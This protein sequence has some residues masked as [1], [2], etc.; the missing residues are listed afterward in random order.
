MRKSRN[1]WRNCLTL[2][3]TLMMMSQLCSVYAITLVDGVPS[4]VKNAEG[5]RQLAV[6]YNGQ[7]GENI[8]VE[9]KKER[10][11]GNPNEIF[12]ISGIAT[13]RIRAYA[14]KTGSEIKLGTYVECLGED[15][16]WFEMDWRDREDQVSIHSL[17][18]LPSITVTDIDFV[19]KDNETDNRLW[20]K[21]QASTG[22][23]FER[24]TAK[25][26]QFAQTQ[27]MTITRTVTEVE[28][29]KN[30]WDVE[31]KV[32]GKAKS[33]PIPTDVVLVLDRSGSMSKQAGDKTRAQLV[34]QASQDLAAEL[35]KAKNTRVAVV[36]FG[37]GKVGERGNKFEHYKRGTWTPF[38][39][40]FINSQWESQ[41]YSNYRVETDF[42]NNQGTLNNAIN[43]ALASPN[44]GTPIALGL[45][46]AGI[47]LKD[48]S[49][50]NKIVILLSDGDATYDRAGGGNGSDMS[51]WIKSDLVNAA[52]Q[53]KA[54]KT[55]IFTIAAG[56]GIS[57]EGK[58]VLQQCASQTNY[59]YEAQDTQ[60][61]LNEV[62][63]DVAS[64]IETT[65]STTKLIENINS[66]FN[67]VIP[68]GE[69]LAG[70]VKVED[71]TTFNSTDWSKVSA[72][73]TQ[74][75]IA[76]NALSKQGMQWEIGDVTSDKPAIIRYRVK[77][78]DGEL[79]KL[80][81]ISNN[82]RM[83]YTDEKGKNVEMAVPN[84]SLKA[85][86]AQVDV[87]AYLDGKEMSVPELTVWAKVP[88]D[89]TVGDLNLNGATKIDTAKQEMVAVGGQS[90]EEMLNNNV[91]GENLIVTGFVVDG[92]AYEPEELI[93]NG[94]DLRNVRSQVYQ[95][96]Q[97]PDIDQVVDSNVNFIQPEGITNV[98]AEVTFKE[99]KSTDIAYKLDITPLLNKELDGKKMMHFDLS[100][101][102][103]YVADV[104]S[105]TT[106]LTKDTN[107]SVS[108]DASHVTINFTDQM[109]ENQKLRIG[110]YIPTKMD[111]QID[112]K[113]YKNNYTVPKVEIAVPVVVAYKPIYTQVIGGMNREV[114]G[115]E[116]TETKSI[117]LAYWEMS[118]IS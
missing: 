40:Q 16:N 112:Y 102:S 6:T 76:E 82:A 23:T 105:G 33:E 41:W 103:V 62:M 107:Y 19:S 75:T 25:N 35:T 12:S 97:S 81:P 114:V 118:K 26:V 17:D 109:V 59:A 91:S 108:T 64:N 57:S 24:A 18:Q 49:A 20:I 52:D 43:S 27:G 22:G 10:T 86:W 14:Y 15:G 96:H 7:D 58:N 65:A 94:F 9:L 89:F 72:V 111:Q 99:P 85:S 101:A 48:S 117:T 87:K 21:M 71:Y 68:V 2:L 39:K 61:A 78:I 55:T 110:I 31:V 32:Q 116:Q 70:S 56:D 8:Q 37:G 1:I 29:L 5:Y 46:K 4:E 106:V 74:G 100:R 42:T 88:D 60:A 11:Q 84:R 113:A 63:S 54:Q 53:V 77:M 30:V 36:S 92:T 93:N 67:V 95:E 69:N 115:N 51:D 44:G 47:L 45:V 28:G 79:G 3:L 50:T 98:T 73:M 38:M 34:K 13:L 80:Y 66:V 90:F 104:T 83:T